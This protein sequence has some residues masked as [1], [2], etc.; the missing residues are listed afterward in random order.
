MDPLKKNFDPKYVLKRS[1]ANFGKTQKKSAHSMRSLNGYSENKILG[2]KL[3]PPPGLVGLI[4]LILQLLLLICLI[5]LLLILMRLLLLL[6]LPFFVN[7]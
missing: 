3:A 5:L 7:K 6:A 1:L 2:A 4:S